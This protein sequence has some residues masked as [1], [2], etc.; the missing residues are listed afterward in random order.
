MSGSGSANECVGEVPLILR[1]VGEC[2][3]EPDTAVSIAT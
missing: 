3:G 1:N 2:A